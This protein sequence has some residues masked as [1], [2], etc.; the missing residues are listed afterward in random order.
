MFM[1]TIMA[2]EAEGGLRVLA[3][4]ILGRFLMNRDNN[5]RYVALN[6][7][8]KVVS[9]D[10][11][12]IQRHRSL[13]VDCLKVRIVVAAHRMC[14]LGSLHHQQILAAIFAPSALCPDNGCCDVQD[15]D[16]SIRRRALDL[17]YALVTKNN[18]RALVKELL[19]YLVLATGD[20][21]FKSDLTD[22]I[23]TVVDRFAPDRR[24]H[25]DT[26]IRVLATVRFAASVVCSYHS[27]LCC[28]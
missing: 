16:I 21:E 6:T 10:T 11:K 19:N 26:V 2:I 7:L 5:I 25:I 28:L 1:Q 18:V 13:V 15:A 24:W 23:C 27:L 9:T 20:K 12:A 22:K 17:I 3:V 4:N 8:C 14:L